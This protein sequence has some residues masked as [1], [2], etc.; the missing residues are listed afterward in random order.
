MAASSPAGSPAAL[1]EALSEL[2]FGD[3]QAEQLE[4]TLGRLVTPDFRQRIHGKVYG[5]EAYGGRV[6]EMRATVSGGRVEVVEQLQ[7][8]DRIV[9][10]YL[11]HVTQAAGPEAT[12]ESSIFARLAPD[13]R[14]R[15]LAE[16]A[17]VVEDDDDRDL[18]LPA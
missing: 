11:F 6:R 4:D 5:R 1:V 17:R 16:L 13:G 15:S 8:G 12:Y 7:D 14:I 10:R 2:F 3:E 9:G 18:L